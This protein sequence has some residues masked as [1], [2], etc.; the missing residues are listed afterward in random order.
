MEKARKLGRT[1][2][3]ALSPGLI[4]D[5][6][7]SSCRCSTLTSLEIWRARHWEHM[8]KTYEKQTAKG[9]SRQASAS[10]SCSPALQRHQDTNAHAHGVGPLGRLPPRDDVA[11][12]SHQSICGI[13]TNADGHRSLFDWP[14]QREGQEPQGCCYTADQCL[15]DH[16]CSKFGKRGHRADKRW[17]KTP[18]SSTTPPG[19]G[20]QE[21]HKCCIWGKTEHLAASCRMLRCVAP[22]PSVSGGSETQLLSY[23]TI[24]TRAPWTV[25]PRNWAPGAPIFLTKSSKL[26]LWCGC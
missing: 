18:L 8:I 1:W 9:F 17:S 16:V 13:V 23:L 25:F 15:S 24:D 20:E 5:Q 4:S 7:V 26:Q 2:C 6:R 12:E 21:N 14:G 22:D 11:Y 10:E 3:S 19:K